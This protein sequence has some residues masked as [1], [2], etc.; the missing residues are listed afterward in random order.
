MLGYN[1]RCLTIQTRVVYLLSEWQIEFLLL[2]CAPKFNFA[3][4][5]IYLFEPFVA[6]PGILLWNN[7]QENYEIGPEHVMIALCAY[8]ITLWCL[9]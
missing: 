9:T 4:D 5:T 6:K 8:L 1:N 7:N 3:Y 2:S